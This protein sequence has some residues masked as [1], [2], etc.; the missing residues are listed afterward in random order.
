M[1][2]DSS[3]GA[4]VVFLASAIFGFTVVYSSVFFYPLIHQAV[5]DRKYRKE[6]FQEQ[7]RELDKYR[8][9]F[10]QNGYEVNG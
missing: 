9:V 1:E 5:S 2:Q 4:A 10:I 8:N 6:L 7:Q 3:I